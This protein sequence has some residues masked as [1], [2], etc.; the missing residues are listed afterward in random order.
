MFQLTKALD[1]WGTPDFKDVLNK[2]IVERVSAEQLPLQQGLSTGSYALHDTFEI[3]IIS[4][5]EEA[6]LIR[7]KAG[8][9][10]SGIIAGC[11]CADDP[12]PLNAASEYCEV[13]FEI[14]KITAETTVVLLAEAAKN[15]S[16]ETSR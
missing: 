6:G 1:A 12:T 13:Q 10:Y 5:V 7:A 8:I 4:V 16:D 9:F 11:S 2:E 15:G 14:N 3:M